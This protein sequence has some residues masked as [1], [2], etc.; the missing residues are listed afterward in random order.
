VRGGSLTVIPV[1]PNLLASFIVGDAA[2]GTTQ[3]EGA[4]G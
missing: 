1:P 2:D 4:S 3:S